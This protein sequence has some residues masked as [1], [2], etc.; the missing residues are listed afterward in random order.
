MDAVTG[1]AESEMSK[2]R[3]LGFRIILKTKWT[4]PKIV[5]GINFGI[6]GIHTLYFELGFVQLKISYLDFRRDL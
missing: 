4:K 1:I 3:E 5:K 6:V 2:H